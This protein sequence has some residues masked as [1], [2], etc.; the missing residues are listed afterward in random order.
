MRCCKQL[1]TQSFCAEIIQKMTAFSEKG[2]CGRTKVFVTSK[3]V[4]G[5][6]GNPCQGDGLECAHVG[7]PGF[8]LLFLVIVDWWPH[9]D[10]TKELL[11]SYHESEHVKC[12]GECMFFTKCLKILSFFVYFLLVCGKH[13]LQS[14]LCGEQDEIPRWRTKALRAP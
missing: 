4:Q 12:F 10:W 5:F 3:D 6:A 1:V 11:H 2:L 8:R 14:L 9:L 7:G 13:F